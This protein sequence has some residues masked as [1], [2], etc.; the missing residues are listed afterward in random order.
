MLPN[1]IGNI[2]IKTKYFKEK[3]I[4]KMESLTNT[5]KK[6]STKRFSEIF[7][8]NHSNKITGAVLVLQA[9]LMLIPIIFTN[10]FPY[11]S[12]FIRGI[13]LAGDV[14]SWIIYWDYT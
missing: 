9:I 7:N 12:F 5:L 6:Y 13:S 4:K 8:F 1:V 14:Y 11:C 10:L 2:E 3:Y